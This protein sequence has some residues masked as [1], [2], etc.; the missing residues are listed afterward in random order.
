MTQ[1][2]QC[3]I[4]CVHCQEVQWIVLEQGDKLSFDAHSLGCPVNT[5]Y[6]RY[7]KHVVE[8]EASYELDTTRRARGI[9]NLPCEVYLYSVPTELLEEAA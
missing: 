7:G 1:V 9:D 2:K 6:L 8:Q 4:Q 5:M 3:F